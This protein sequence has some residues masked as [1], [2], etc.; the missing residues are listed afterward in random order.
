MNSGITASQQD[1][2]TFPTPM[3]MNSININTLSEAAFKQ[4]IHSYDPKERY[5]LIFNYKIKRIEI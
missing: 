1:K 3:S 2:I 4:H 5:C